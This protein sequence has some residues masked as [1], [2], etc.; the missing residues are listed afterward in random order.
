MFQRFLTLWSLVSA[1]WQGGPWSL[2]LTLLCLAQNSS[3]FFWEPLMNVKS[4]KGPGCPS[5]FFLS[6]LFI[7]FSFFLS[8]L[9][10]PYALPCFFPFPSV[11]MLIASF[12]AHSLL[13][14]LNTARLGTTYLL[15]SKPDNLKVPYSDQLLISKRK[16]TNAL[17]LWTKV[18]FQK[19]GANAGSKWEGTN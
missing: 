13:S 3:R 15:I 2:C 18:D 9:S 19:F 14:F 8:F 10:I 6:L 11:I 17:G 7:S 5:L 1:R 16:G 12:F 4:R